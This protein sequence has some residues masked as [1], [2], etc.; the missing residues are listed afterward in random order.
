[1]RSRPRLRLTLVTLLAGLT[2]GTL[3]LARPP[4]HGAVWSR[5][6]D[7]ALVVAWVV[8]LA[9]AG[10]L[11]ATT[12]ACTLALGCSR[13]RVAHRL[14][15]ALPFGVRRLV[16]LAIASSFVVIPALPAHA[17]PPAP[18]FGVVDQP[19]V[20]APASAPESTG[21]PAEPAVRAT[22]APPPAPAPAPRRVVVRAGD[23]LWGIARASLE[24]SGRAQ[25]TDTDI[26]RYWHTVV[27]AN[28]ST[29]R[30]GNPAL[31]F[32]GEIVTL[33]P[34]PALS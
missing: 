1:M 11:F 24:R 21:V 25:P 34:P 10:W 23:N 8:A 28:R 17:A 20:R 14:S 4:L 33:P 18:P 31:I 2:V 16:E 7:L 13:P 9:A 27:T 12:A 15:C 5:G 6:A 3:V 29:L 32:P 26:A 22:P 30:S 19:V